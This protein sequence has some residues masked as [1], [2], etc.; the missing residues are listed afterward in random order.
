MTGRAKC[1][2]DDYMEKRMGRLSGKVAFITGTA[3]AQ[4][5]AAALL[6]AREGASI[7]GCDF[8]DTDD[9]TTA[10]VREKGGRMHSVCPV[11][12]ADP[13]DAKAW[14][15][16]GIKEFG[17]IDILY[18]NASAA[19]FSFISDMTQATWSYTMRNE[20]DLIFNTVSAA[21]PHFVAQESGVIINTASVAGHRGN[22]GQGSLAHCAAKGG[23][24]AMTK[25]MA[26]EGGARGIRANSISPGIVRTPSMAGWLTPEKVAAREKANLLGRLGN[27]EDIAYCA[28]YLASDEASFVTG[29]DFT[30]DGG[31]SAV[32]PS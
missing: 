22:A 26:A 13:E 1:E 12:L 3:G 2:P 9:E 6:F 10:L 17:K 4:G 5:R 27:P 16:F 24:I 23:V 11:D 21:W 20:L 28:L 18:N 25:Q 29:A 31:L 8:R 32:S 30:V 7:I 15:D 19:Q 14:I